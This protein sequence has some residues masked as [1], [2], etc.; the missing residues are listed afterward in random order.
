MWPWKKRMLPPWK[1][2]PDIPQGCIGWRMGY[3]E[4]YL[5]QFST[6]WDA[7]S[8]EEKRSY[9]RKFPAPEEWS[10]FYSE[11]YD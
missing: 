10:G 6:W 2:Y 11:I 9:A 3:G 4:D 5:D 7:S 8:L 1:K